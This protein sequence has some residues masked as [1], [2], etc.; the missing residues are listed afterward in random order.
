VPADDAEFLVYFFG[1]VLDGH[2]ASVADGVP[3][4]LG[5]P[6]RDFA[7]YAQATAAADVWNPHRAA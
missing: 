2:N 3:R 7:D 1:T 5:R 6:P 4:V